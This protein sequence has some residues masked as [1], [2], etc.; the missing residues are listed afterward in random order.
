MRS[1]VVALEQ[2]AADR[3]PGQGGPD[4]RALALTGALQAR[5]P[6]AEVLLFGSRAL[7]DWRP[8]SDLDLA[9]IGNDRDAAEEALAQS[10]ALC[11]ELYDGDAPYTQLFH[12]TR[13][14]FDKCR[15]SLPHIAGQVQRHGLKP[16]GEPLPPMPQDNHWEGVRTLLQ[17][18]RR[19]LADALEAWGGENPVRALVSAHGAIELAI[20]AALGA[21]GIDITDA[22]L[23][24]ERLRHHLLVALGNRLPAAQEARLHALLPPAQLVELTQFRITSPYGGDHPTMPPTA[25]HLIL[26]GVQKANLML[27]TYALSTLDK[28][29]PDVGYAE[30]VGDDAL[31]GFGSVSLDYYAQPEIE[32]RAE[33]RVFVEALRALLGNRLPEHQI[34]QV[35]ADW[36]A[37]GPP[38]DAMVRVGV[39]MASPDTWATLLAERDDAPPTSSSRHATGNGPLPA[40]FHRYPMPNDEQYRKLRT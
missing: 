30:W 11:A 29:A 38:A 36:R 33:L 35:V 2:S 1:M 25:D 4:A 13:A 24:R 8:E 5:L 14:E 27:A 39:V 26:D 31:A 16:D 12:F 17:T 22:G 19:N 37:H 10:A 9:V 18:C 6:D 7:G 15:T 3:S 20:K 34:E 21:S 40:K 28:S 23:K 32:A